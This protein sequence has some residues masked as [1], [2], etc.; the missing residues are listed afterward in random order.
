MSICVQTLGFFADQLLVEINS[1]F[2]VL[3]IVKVIPEL[4]G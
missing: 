2:G 3:S 4:E 1:I